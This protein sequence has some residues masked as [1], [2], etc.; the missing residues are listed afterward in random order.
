M[1]TLAIDGEPGRMFRIVPGSVRTIGRAVGV[2]FVLDAPLVSRV[3]CRLTS[4]AEGALEVHDLESTNGTFVNGQRVQTARLVQGDR[5][6][7]GGVELL[8]TAD[9]ET[10]SPSE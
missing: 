7:V 1:W 6:R 8:V 2:D 9:V 3:H 4:L 10:R 5:L